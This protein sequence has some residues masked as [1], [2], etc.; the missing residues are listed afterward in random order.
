M[1]EMRE[2]VLHWACRLMPFSRFLNAEETLQDLVLSLVA[3]LPAVPLVKTKPAHMQHSIALFSPQPLLHPL[4]ALIFFIFFFVF[5]Y[6]QVAE[7][8][9]T[10]F[11]DEE[12]SVRVPLREKYTS[13]LQGLRSS[14]VQASTSIQG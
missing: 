4:F 10:V 3:E 12:E 9:V 11:P 1:C 14:T 2:E 7:T 6:F 13:L 8:L 5:L